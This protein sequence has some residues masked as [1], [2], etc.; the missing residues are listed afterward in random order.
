MK[1]ILT[2]GALLICAALLFGCA[3]R[4]YAD[5]VSCAEL[6]DTMLSVLDDGE[7]YSDFD[8]VQRAFYFEDS[9]EADDCRMVYS[10]DTNDINEIG[11][12]HAPNKAEAQDIAEDCRE[13]VED[14]RQNSRAFIASYAPSELSKLDGAQVRIYG[15][16][17][18]YTILPTELIE[19]VFHEVERVLTYR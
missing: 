7:E 13:Y 19:S 17:V 16:Y 14:M 8:S 1:K 11:I 6:V 2:V 18:I 9:H 5:N 4:E 3:R 15:N 10:L 12:F